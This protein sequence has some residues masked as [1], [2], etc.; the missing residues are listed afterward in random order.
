MLYSF[1]G[2]IENIYLAEKN[3]ALL[4]DLFKVKKNMFLPVSSDKFFVFKYTYLFLVLTIDFCNS[5]LIFFCIYLIQKRHKDKN[6]LNI[7]KKRNSI[8]KGEGVPL[9]NFEGGPGVL[10][11]NFEG[12]PGPTFKL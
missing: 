11:L 8:K 9:L 5:Q 6:R 12:G 3:W 4:T 7:L 1:F 10:L 2:T